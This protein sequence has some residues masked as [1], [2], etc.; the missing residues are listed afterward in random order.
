MGMV[1]PDTLQMLA[2]LRQAGGA[3]PRA[4]RPD[5]GG[6]QGM[7]WT[8]LDYSQRPYSTVMGG[9]HGVQRGD[10]PLEFM[11]KAMSGEKQFG[12]QDILVSA[13]ADPDSDVTKWVGIG[14][15]VTVG[16]FLDPLSYLTLGV[17]RV[18]RLQRAMQAG[19]KTLSRANLARTGG[20]SPL[21]VRV[22]ITGDEIPL[23]P[24][25]VSE[26]A[27]RGMD[28][29]G[30]KIAQTRAYELLDETFGGVQKHF[31]KYPGL[32]EFAQARRAGK[33]ATEREIR[34]MLMDMQRM[35]GDTDLPPEFHRVAR[36]ML[37][38][39]DVANF[40]DIFRELDVLADPGRYWRGAGDV[41]EVLTGPHVAVQSADDVI[42]RAHREAV[43][44]RFADVNNLVATR[45]VSNVDGVLDEQFILR[46]AAPNPEDMPVD[47]IRQNR[48]QELLRRLDGVEG[49]K[50]DFAEPMRELVRTIDHAQDTLMSR[51][52]KIDPNAQMPIEAYLK[53]MFPVHDY[54]MWSQGRR[55]VKDKTKFERERVAELV[56]EGM[57]T[58][59]ARRKVQDEI[60]AN[61]RWAAFS[62]W[63]PDDFRSDSIPHQ[64]MQRKYRQ[65]IDDANEFFEKMGLDIRFETDTTNI[66]AAMVRD[67]E[68]WAHQFDLFEF[69]NERFGIGGDEL[70]ALSRAEQARYAPIDFHVPFLSE[71]VKNPFADRYIPTTARN[72]IDNQADIY[73][74]FTNN[75]GFQAFLDIA[76]GFRRWWSAWTLG[77]FPAY[78][79]RNLGSDIMLAQQAGLNF[80]TAEGLQA[81]GASGALLARRFRDESDRTWF[82][83]LAGGAMPKQSAALDGML[84]DINRS[85]R[86]SGS[87]PRNRAGEMVDL[88]SDDILHMAQEF[89]V[90]GGG[91]Y[92]DIDSAAR[93]ALDAASSG[94][95]PGRGAK[96]VDYLPFTGLRAELA[97]RSAQDASEILRFGFGGGQNIQDFTKGA[98]WMHTFRDGARRGMDLERAKL[99]AATTV[100]KHLFDYKDMTPFEQNIMKL[101][102]P[103]YTFTSKNLPLQIEMLATQPNRFAYL[104]RA[105]HS[106]WNGFQHDIDDMDIPQYLKRYFGIPV[107]TVTDADGVDK[108]S[109]WNPMGWVP[110]SE[111]NELADAFRNSEGMQAFVLSRLNPMLKEP[112]E[113]ILNYDTFTGRKIDDGEVQDI[114]GLAIPDAPDWVPFA[115]EWF[116]NPRMVHFLRNF[117][118]VTELDRLNPGDWWTGIGQWSG[119]FTQD[120]AH[121]REAPQGQRALRTFAGFNIQTVD[122]G[123]ELE[124]KVRDA[125]REHSRLESR[126]RWAYSRGHVAEAERMMRQANDHLREAHRYSERLQEVRRSRALQQSNAQQ[127]R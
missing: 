52:R 33:D 69:A 28:W 14:L 20:Y 112:F 117:R 123:E 79:L 109:V 36:N 65:S 110:M 70:R 50:A 97:G 21:N 16:G 86:E 30:G 47:I 1:N 53:H 32:R 13:G 40:K 2:Q 68:R 120:R 95:N 77:P 23:L 80:F 88:T 105:Y 99:H 37:E 60:A 24:Q 49:W 107:A 74:A 73:R 81:Y 18:G 59:A 126:A 15:D 113:Q 48:Q 87:L 67:S 122:T 121:R 57:D 62:G 66:A 10:D 34:D 91:W 4:A 118:L 100:R 29:L 26:R 8:A 46:S 84:T 11:W 56:G 101:L 38:G 54:K 93:A 41:G 96:L 19:E 12:F 61:E 7:F 25:A 17:N 55:I 44:Q 102:V 72:I 31:A 111:I 9:I 78:H 90:I 45:R 116:T 114:F 92:R 64:F 85:L 35:L 58:T 106:A 71:G 104:N 119:T 3:A 94:V 27:G 63:T 75:E 39:E 51:V 6:G 82:A 108:V 89:D 98:L 103:F 76:H 43:A 42:G 83:R 115:G 125:R 124:R 127:L 5:D 22:P